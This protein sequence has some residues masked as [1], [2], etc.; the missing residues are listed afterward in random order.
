[1]IGDMKISEFGDALIGII[2][3]Y[4][5]E[6]GLTPNTAPQPE[7]SKPNTKRVTFDL[8]KSG[9]T[10]EQIAEERGLVTGTIEGHLAYFIARK[11]LKILEFVPKEDVEQISGYF[12]GAESLSLEQAKAHFGDL[13]SYGQLRMVLEHFRS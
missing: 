1:G 11:E 2:Q 3:A 9:K 5:K 4:C 10:I 6:N 8:Y 13:Y 12:S 7:P